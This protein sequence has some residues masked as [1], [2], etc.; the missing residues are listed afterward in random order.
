LVI[1]EVRP[2]K[3]QEILNDF[4]P[5]F[6]THS[7]QEIREKRKVNEVYNTFNRTVFAHQEYQNLYA[8]TLTPNEQF[9]RHS[10][11]Y[12]KEDEYERAVLKLY[13]QMLHRVSA[14]I[15]SNYRRNTFQRQRLISQVIIEHKSQRSGL[16]CVPHIHATIAVHDDWNSRF[17]DCFQRNICRDHLSV[18]RSIFTGKSGESLS[19]QINSTRLVPINN[20]FRWQSYTLKQV[21]DDYQGAGF[22]T[23]GLSKVKKKH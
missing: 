14:S 7:G 17:L 18:N 9:L 12:F 8:L 6:W 10:G 15:E 20:L 2:I 21:T 1:E 16:I 22:A 19:S 11:A 13:D 4:T 3:T 5:E 23:R